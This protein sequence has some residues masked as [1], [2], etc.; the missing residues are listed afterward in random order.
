MGITSLSRLSNLEM[1]DFDELGI[2]EVSHRRKLW[3][4]VQRIKMAVKGNDDFVA[5]KDDSP[6]GG[7]G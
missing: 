7:G 2:I 6:E 1:D 4:L 3:Y 5:G